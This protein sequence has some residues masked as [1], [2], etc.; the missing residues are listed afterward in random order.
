M[1]IFNKYFM[2]CISMKFNAITCLRILCILM[3]SQLHFYICTV[4]TNTPVNRYHHYITSIASDG[5]LPTEDTDH[6]RTVAL[7]VLLPISE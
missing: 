5:H 4:C 7:R 6:L 2:K 3:L 1:Q